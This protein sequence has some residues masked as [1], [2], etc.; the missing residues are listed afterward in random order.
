MMNYQA[1]YGQITKVTYNENVLKKNSHKNADT[2]IEDSYPY[3][4]KLVQNTSIYRI[5]GK[6]NKPIYVGGL[7]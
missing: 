2:K 1:L 7:D 5:S 3:I 6:I 4:A